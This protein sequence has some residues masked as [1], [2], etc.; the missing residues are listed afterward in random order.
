MPSKRNCRGWWDQQQDLDDIAGN[1]IK[2]DAEEL[3]PIRDVAKEVAN[4][5]PLPIEI[6]E[7]IFLYCL[8]TSSFEFPNHVCLTYNNV[9]NALPVCKHFQQMGLA[10]LPRIYINTC[11]YLPKPRK[12][13]ELVGNIQRLIRNFLY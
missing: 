12:N 5:E 8:T 10:H 1:I 9:I 13:G 11:D 6:I 2:N 3:V 4:L 7:K